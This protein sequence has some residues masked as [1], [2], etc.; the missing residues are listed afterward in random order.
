METPLR[1]VC[2]GNGETYSLKRKTAQGAL[3]VLYAVSLLF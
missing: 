1:V 3:N 2:D